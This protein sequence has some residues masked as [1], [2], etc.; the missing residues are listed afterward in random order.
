MLY[1]SYNGTLLAI[2]V[3]NMIYIMDPKLNSSRDKEIL[4]AKVTEHT[5]KITSLCWSID[6]SSVF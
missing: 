2:A 6:V 5:D 3:S 4:I 1:F